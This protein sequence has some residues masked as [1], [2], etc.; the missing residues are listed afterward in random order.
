MLSKKE[1]NFFSGQDLKSKKDPSKKWFCSSPQV[2]LW[3]RRSGI[4]LA[5]TTVEL[6]C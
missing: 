6:A 5:K 3:Q 4:L 1:F 2:C